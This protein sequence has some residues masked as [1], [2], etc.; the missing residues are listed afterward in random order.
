MSKDK[1]VKLR[2]SVAE[3]VMRTVESLAKSPAKE[4][5]GGKFMYICGL[6]SQRLLI[7]LLLQLL[8]IGHYPLALG[9]IFGL[10]IQTLNKA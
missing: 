1:C 6:R 2:W 3:K 9:D 4:I 10:F 8:S 7:I 5:L